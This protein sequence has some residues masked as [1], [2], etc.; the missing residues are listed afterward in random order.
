MAKQDSQIQEWI[1]ELVLRLAWLKIGQNE[2][3]GAANVYLLMDSDMDGH[4]TLKEF[5]N[6]LEYIPGFKE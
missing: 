4:I 6:G 5:R 2:I 3:H 1:R